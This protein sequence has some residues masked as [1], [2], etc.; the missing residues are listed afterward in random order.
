MAKVEALRKLI[1]D[2]MSEENLTQTAAALEA[3]IAT[4]TLGRFLNGKTM[5]PLFSTLTRMAFAAGVDIEFKK[6]RKPKKRAPYSS[7][8]RQPKLPRRRH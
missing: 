4:G 7:G 5:A 6:I 3:R 8:I 2:W 1:R